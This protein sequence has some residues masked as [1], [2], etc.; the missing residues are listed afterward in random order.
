MRHRKAG[1]KL[2]RTASH[3]KAMLSNLSTSVLRHKKVMTTIAKAKEVRCLVEHLITKAKQATAKLKTAPEDKAVIAAMVHARRMVA[4][5]VN[6]RA[7][8]KELFNE[9]APKLEERKGGYTRV[10]KLGQRH[11]DAAEVAILELVDYNTGQVKKAK[12]EKKE[13]KKETAKK[14]EP[15]AAP[16]AEKKT[17]EVTAEAATA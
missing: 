12:P 2:K 17:E 5:T 1:R 7:V 14:K 4:K 9:I 11:G 6:D 8:V 13:K 16:K 15:K 3:R 10:I